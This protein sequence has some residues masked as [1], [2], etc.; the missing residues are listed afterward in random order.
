MLDDSIKVF[1]HK[2]TRKLLNNRN[3]F[4]PFCKRIRFEWNLNA[5]ETKIFSLDICLSRFML[6]ALLSQSEREM[7]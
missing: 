6:F 3:P 5:A 7:G 2:L 4:F 1:Y